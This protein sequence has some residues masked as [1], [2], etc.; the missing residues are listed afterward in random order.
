MKQSQ[1]LAFL[2]DEDGKKKNLKQFHLNS[3][4]VSSPPCWKKEIISVSRTTTG[5][6]VLQGG[7]VAAFGK[8]AQISQFKFTKMQ[9]LHLHQT[10]MRQYIHVTPPRKTKDEAASFSFCRFSA[11]ARLFYMKLMTACSHP[12]NTEPQTFLTW[13]Q[14]TQLPPPLL[15][16]GFSA[17]QDGNASKHVEQ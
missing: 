11:G 9:V 4:C 16:L 13:P 5:L 1:S 8:A 14:T 12:C 15:F 7:E 2:S 6:I 10:Q 17:A 3:E